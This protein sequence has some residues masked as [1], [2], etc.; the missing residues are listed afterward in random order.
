MTLLAMRR[1]GL[2]AV[3]LALPSCGDPTPPPQTTEFDP[4]TKQQQLAAIHGEFERNNALAYQYQMMQ[5][6]QHAADEAAR[7][8][9]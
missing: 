4:V 9:S 1:Y 3:I 2:L 5:T 6:Q 7:R 8:K